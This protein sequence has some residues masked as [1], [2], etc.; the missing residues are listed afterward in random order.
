MQASVKNT[1]MILATAPTRPI[2]MTAT[3]LRC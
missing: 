3:R 2:I 1:H